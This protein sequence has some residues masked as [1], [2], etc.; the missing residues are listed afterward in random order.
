VG[1]EKKKSYAESAESAEFAEKR[2][3][4]RSLRSGQQKALA[5]GRDDKFTLAGEK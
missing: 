4:S 3:K 1:V 2:R 5:S